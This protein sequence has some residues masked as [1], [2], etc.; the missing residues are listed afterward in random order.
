MFK[1]LFLYLTVFIISANI[2]DAQWINY[3]YD[4]T[5]GMSAK[6]VSRII[7]SHD[8]FLWMGTDDG[9][10]K[11]DRSI[12]SWR[13]F[14]NLKEL[15]ILDIL[16]DKNHDIWA[17]S[18][19]G[20]NRFDGINWITYT[21][22]N[23]LP[24]NIIMGLTKDKQ[25]N[26]WL[27][28]YG[29][30]VCMYNFSSW[31]T[32]NKN[33][34]LPT[35][36]FRS[37]FC[38][39]KG[40][41]WFGTSNFGVVQFDGTNWQSFTTTDGLSGNTIL[42]I[43]ED[44]QNQICLSTTSG[45]SIYNGTQ[46]TTLTIADGLSSNTVNCVKQDINGNY[47]I[48]TDNGLNIYNGSLF[49][50]ITTAQGLASNYIAD[51]LRDSRGVYWYAHPDKGVSSNNGLVW[52]NYYNLNGLLSNYIKNAIEDKN[53]NLW[54]STGS[55]LSRY[56]GHNWVT[57][58]DVDGNQISNVTCVTVDTNKNIWGCA[59]GQ[60]LFSYDGS[61]WT[62]IKEQNGLLNNYVYYIFIDSENNI[63]VSYNSG[64]SISR[65]DGKNWKHFTAS[66][67]LIAGRINVIF[68]DS[69]KKIWFGSPAGVS[70]YDGF[71]FTNFQN[72][73]N[74]KLL[75]NN[76]SD[77]TE[78]SEGNIWIG[79]GNYSDGGLIKFDGLNWVSCTINLALKNVSSL[80]YDSYGR[81]WIATIN[82]Y[83]YG[84]C[85]TKYYD[86]NWRNYNN[87]LGIPN[88]YFY[89]LFED[90][91]HNIWVCT[92]N[93]IFKGNMKTVAI[94]PTPVSNISDVTNYPNPFSDYTSIN[95]KLNSTTDV[96]VEI[97]DLMGKQLKNYSFK[98]QKPGNYSVKVDGSDLNSGTYIYKLR[99]ENTS[100]SGKINFIKN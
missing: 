53:G 54:F 81:L 62:L 67:G 64:N 73:N 61:S 18:T 43:F 85:I 76:V 8:G 46:W 10:F 4:N 51:I 87:A 65:F 11:Y 84:N 77:I 71:S 50:K 45:I 66:D 72:V 39:S 22:A 92:N 3:N 15:Y 93:G 12:D 88:S 28:T 89:D 5:V 48:G 32:Y 57:F 9:I 33:N 44:N 96:I 99:L 7:E 74:N 23:G 6:S 17:S 25:G 60:G 63:W 37:A 97:N 69:D 49:T 56:D 14:N 20:V 1:K 40:N 79:C 35:N 41:L 26:V 27:A 83:S 21:T 42:N 82:N 90:S 31:K 58:T 52:C 36:T 16:E 80:L 98:N 70:V 86:K 91:K 47:M 24:N 2:A 55:G 19:A 30:G 100:I 95:Y 34:G 78:D 13:K 29:G 59:Y 94:N 75:I 38:D 68:E